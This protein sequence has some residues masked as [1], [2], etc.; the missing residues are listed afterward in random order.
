MAS[1]STRLLADQLHS[2]GPLMMS[3]YNMMRAKKCVSQCSIHGPIRHYH[4]HKRNRPPMMLFAVNAIN[5]RS[6]SSLLH[7]YYNE[8]YRDALCDTERRCRR[9]EKI[10]HIH[11]GGCHS[12]SS[13]PRSP[14]AVLKLRTSA[15]KND[16]KAAFRKVMIH[17]SY[18]LDDP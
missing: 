4:H 16:I 1:S 13:R 6:C 2:Q 14:Y 17:Y 8:Y 10:I 12:F 7:H 15:S 11:A 3:V 18:V 9:Q 5:H